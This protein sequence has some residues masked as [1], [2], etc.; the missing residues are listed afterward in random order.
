VKTGIN[1]VIISDGWKIFPNPTMNNFNLNYSGNEK[2]ESLKLYNTLG[3]VVWS[4]VTGNN[5]NWIINYV[6]KASFLNNTT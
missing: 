1:D 5:K 3:E 2:I 4:T 6:I